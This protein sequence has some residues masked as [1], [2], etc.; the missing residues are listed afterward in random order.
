M[1]TSQNLRSLVR[2]IFIFCG[3][4]AF[5]TALSLIVILL[6]SEG[7]HANYVLANVIGYGCGL[8]SG[9]AMHKNLTFQDQL[10]GRSVNMQ[11]QMAVFLLVFGV[12]YAMQLGLLVVLVE[13]MHLA[14]LPSQILAWFIY[15]AASFAGHKFMTFRNR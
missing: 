5:N 3:V 7:L 9:F 8:A 2:Q 11:T 12:A 6:L 10:E 13:K 15:V 14:N 1:T 4:G